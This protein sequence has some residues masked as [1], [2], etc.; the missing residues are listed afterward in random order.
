MTKKKIYALVLTLLML[1]VAGCSTPQTMRDNKSSDGSYTVVDHTGKEVKIKKKPLRILTVTT[2]LDEIVLG[3]VTPDKLVAVNHILV[4]PKR[5]N[6]THLAEKIP[7]KINRN[8]P[9]ETVASLAPDIVLAQEW[10][11]I[12]NREAIRDL[13]IP[14]VICHQSN[15]IETVK[16]N[17]QLVADAIGESERGKSLVKKMD[18]ELDR[19]VK[20]IEKVPAEKKGKSI[21]LV[22][23]MPTF[24]GAGCI[25]DD[26]CKYTGSRNAKAEAGNKLGQSMTKEQFV[27]CNP[28]Y[29]FIPRYLDTPLITELYGSPYNEDPSL[30]M[31]K[32]VKNDQVRHPWAHY[33]YNVSQDVVYGVQETARMLYGEEFAQPYDR[34]LTVV[35]ENEKDYKKKSDKE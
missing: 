12:A 7:H 9:V 35:P 13:G 10:V 29:I 3:L 31:L 6:I 23:V 8:P 28:D 27:A 5:S 26:A 30:T 19:I 21:A 17:V 15:S 18:D 2:A 22:S 16:K 33:V 25:F 24:G 1:V 4:D 34:F 32:A 20:Q 14:V 11:P